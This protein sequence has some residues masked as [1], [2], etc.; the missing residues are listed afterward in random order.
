M[1]GVGLYRSLQQR[2]GTL[3]IR[4]LAL[5]KKN[6]VSQVEE[7]NTFLCMGRRRSLGSLNSLLSCCL[8]CLG[9]A[10][11]DLS[12]TSFVSRSPLTNMCQWPPYGQMGGLVLP[13]H[14]PGSE[15]HI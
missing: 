2:A 1:G 15:I 12:F 11:C 14:P 5:I 13:R 7:F 8:S 6:Q 4:R 10:S 9:P 3:N